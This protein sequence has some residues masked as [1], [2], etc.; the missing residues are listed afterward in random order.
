MINRRLCLTHPEHDLLPDIGIE[1]AHHHRHRVRLEDI[2]TPPFIGIGTGEIQE[3]SHR[4]PR[5]S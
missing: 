5:P 4:R 3:D 2:E 1:P